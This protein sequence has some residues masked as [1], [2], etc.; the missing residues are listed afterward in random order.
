M[1]KAGGFSQSREPAPGRNLDLEL[2]E[3]GKKKKKDFW[4]S[5][6]LHAFLACREA[7]GHCSFV[8]PCG[9]HGA[10]GRLYEETEG[11]SHRG[12][13]TPNEACGPQPACKSPPLPALT[14]SGDPSLPPRLPQD[15]YQMRRSLSG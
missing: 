3:V 13:L 12:P 15:S 11:G 9:V 5:Q 14:F 4:T 8:P 7:D 1:R 2:Q 10:W 6:Y